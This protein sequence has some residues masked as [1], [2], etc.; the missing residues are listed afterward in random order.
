MSNRHKCRKESSTRLG[1]NLELKYI[2]ENPKHLL[3]VGEILTLSSLADDAEGNA[4]SYMIYNS[5]N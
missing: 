3:E 1:I 2:H 4:I 5:I